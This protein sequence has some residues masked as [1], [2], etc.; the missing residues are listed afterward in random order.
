M[1]KINIINKTIKSN[2]PEAYTLEKEKNFGKKVGEIIEYSPFEC[3][4]LFENKKAKVYDKNK[5]L[6]KNEIE[7]KLNS[8]DKKFDTKY[9]VFKDLTKK[10]YT[11]K[12]GLKFGAEFRVYEK[13]KNNNH[14]KWLLFTQRDNEKNTWH[15]F[16][17][18]NRVAHSTNKK[19]LLAIVDDEKEV[20]YFEINWFK[21]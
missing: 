16:S 11:L 8:I 3:M 20:I 17:S 13:N 4:Y 1:I 15:E 5:E 12:T 14:S 9:T 6:T 18:K 19:L 2:S 10:G 21:N 7:K